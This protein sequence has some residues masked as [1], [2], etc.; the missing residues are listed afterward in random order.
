MNIDDK[1]SFV[2]YVALLCEKARKKV[3]VLARLSTS[4]DSKSKLL[5]FHSFIMSNFNYCTSIWGF[6]SQRLLKRIEKLQYRSLQLIYRDFISSYKELRAKGNLELF[7]TRHLCIMMVQIFKILHK[8]GPQ[9]LH[10]M[11]KEKEVKYLMRSNSILEYSDFQSNLEKIVLDIKGPKSGICFQILL[12]VVKRPGNL[13]TRSLS[14]REST[15]CAMGVL[16]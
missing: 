5:L 12:K 1:L 10:G 9:Y 16:P 8:E 3:N 2:D 13:K 7:Y 11:F 15:A 6:C 14:G 4:L